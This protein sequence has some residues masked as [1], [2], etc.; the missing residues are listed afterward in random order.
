M[1]IS[2]FTTIGNE[3]IG[4]D[5]RG[6]CYLEALESYCDLADEVVIVNGGSKIDT[7]PSLKIK[8]VF[9]PWPWEWSWE[10]LPKAMNFGLDSCTGDWV[11][12]C[13]IDYIFH[14]NDIP[15][16]RKM[17][18]AS[19]LSIVA[20]FQKF[21]FVLKD[22]F[23]QK[24][25]L[26]IAIN[27]LATG[28]MYGF[29]QATNT[30]T[31]LCYPIRITGE[32]EKGIPTGEYEPEKFSKLGLPVFNYDY[33]FKTKEA[34]STEFYRFSKAYHRYFGSWRF[35]ETEKKAF[36]VFIDMMK[37]RLSKCVYTIGDK[38]YS[39]PKYIKRAINEVTP[40]MFGYNGWGLLK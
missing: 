31:D 35:G 12:R 4:P 24:G 34:T 23:Y 40:E 8:Q 25:G 2:I 27:A 37:G 26:P 36:G 3:R 22:M 29:G 30:E 39:H 18:D 32:N 6:D 33:T 5:R 13:D 38:G 11:I 21:S 14:E 9:C 15:T 16:I 10:Q 7:F 20:T 1:K 19:P 28:P 17:L